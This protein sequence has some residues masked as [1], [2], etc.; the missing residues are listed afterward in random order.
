MGDATRVRLLRVLEREELS[1]GEVARIMQ[2]PQSTVSRHLKRLLDSGWAR[3]RNEGTAGLYRMEARSLPEGAGAL[4]A[5]AKAQLEP[6]TTASDDAR[7][8]SVLAERRT[9]S[10]T[11]FGRVGGDWAQLRR[12][13]FGSAFSCEAMLSLL[14]PDL[15][16]ADLGCG[17]G[18][19][20][21]LLAPLVQRVIAVDREPAMLD[22]ARRRLEG[23]RNVTFRQG[24]LL[25]L[26]L[27]P[28]EV[29][30]AILMLVLHHIERPERAIAECARI[31]SDRGRVLVVDMVRHD[32]ADYAR[33]MG[34][35]HLGFT[36]ADARGWAKASGLSLR[37]WRILRADPEAKGPALFAAQLERRR[38][39]P[40]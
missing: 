10:R 18:D 28:G 4:W 14:D 13:L 40:L 21:E 27:G 37:R 15:A 30:A 22:A 24:D 3:R 33:T 1:V 6:A 29:D 5:L 38:G 11:F 2:L 7:I 35:R 20:S 9:D 31:L 16:I 25:S 34:H 19:A 39:E 26:P 8:A 23:H 17:T 36:E 12:E 32:R